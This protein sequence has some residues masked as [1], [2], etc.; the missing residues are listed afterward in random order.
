M[1]CDTA[2]ALSN[3]VNVNPDS[4]SDQNEYLHSTS[5]A[6][7]GGISSSSAN[8]INGD[9]STKSYDGTNVNEQNEFKQLENDGSASSK[10]NYISKYSSN[11]RGLFQDSNTKIITLP[12]PNPP[13]T[14]T[15][16][17]T[18]RYLQPPPLPPANVNY[19]F[20]ILSFVLLIKN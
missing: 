8:I 12:N 3:Q 5:S 20:V 2:C 1:R 10:I 18:I 15:Q 11:D 6:I 4:R 7:N 14:H 17:I 9:F 19:F 16:K 13:R